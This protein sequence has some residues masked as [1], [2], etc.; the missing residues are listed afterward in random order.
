MEKELKRLFRSY[1]I[2]GI[3]F[4]IVIS[5]VIISEKYGDAVSNTLKKLQAVRSDIISMREAQ[6]GMD[7]TLTY[8]KALIPPDIAS[9]TPDERI[10]IVL[11]DL[12]RRIKDA[13]ITITEMEHKGIEVTLP[14]TIKAV[15][16]GKLIAKD[17]TAFVQN[18]GYLQSLSLPFFSIGGITMS[19]SQDKTSVSYE[20]KGDLRT[21]K[22]Q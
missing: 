1:V 15:M 9:R 7:K 3:V 8:A 22:L 2:S 13:K 14:V 11:D 6:A 5:G 17:Y 20:I 4:L 18:V 10:F 21:I 16:S 19:Q 12:N